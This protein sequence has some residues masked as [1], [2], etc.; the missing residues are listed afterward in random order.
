M[1]PDGEVRARF[2]ATQNLAEHYAMMVEYADR[3]EAEN[4][5]LRNRLQPFADQAR[6]IDVNNKMDNLPPSEGFERFKFYG[7]YAAISYGDCK[8]ALEVLNDGQ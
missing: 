1:N 4:E 3:L 8:R 6:I 7:S 5:L 2:A